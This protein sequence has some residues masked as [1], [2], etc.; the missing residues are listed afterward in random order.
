VVWFVGCGWLA[1]MVH[2]WVS[3]MFRLSQ[4]S[5]NLWMSTSSIELET[6]SNGRVL[7]MGRVVVWASHIESKYGDLSSVFGYVLSL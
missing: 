3:P 5:S 2:G 1:G 7:G 4:G 6:H